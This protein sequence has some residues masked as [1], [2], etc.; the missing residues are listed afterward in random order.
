LAEGRISI[1]RLHRRSVYVLV[2]ALTVLAVA[3]VASARSRAVAGNPTFTPHPP[4]GIKGALLPSQVHLWKYNKAT[5]RYVT[6]PGK[7][8][9]LY[10]PHIRKASKTWTI[11][12]AEGWAANAFSVPIHK[13]VYLYAKLAGVKIIYCDNQFKTDQAISCAEQ[14]VS[15]HPDFAIESNWQ[16]GVVDALSKIWS[17]AHVPTVNDDVWHPNSIFF[18][19]NNYESG[20]IA[21][22]AAGTYAKQK[23]GC[24]DVWVFLGEHKEEGAAADL[25][26]SGFAD[27]VQEVCGKLPSGQINRE[28]MAAGTT[29]Q[30]ITVTTDWLTAHPQA[31]H[32]VATSIDD[33]R[34]TGMAKA[35]L[36]TRRDGVAAGQGADTVGIAAVKDAPVSKNDYLGTVAFFNNKYA[37]YM[38]SI[39][40]DVLEGKPVPQEVHL[41]HVFITH[42]DLGKTD[43]TSLP[44]QHGC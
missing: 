23:W 31:K 25:R 8:P 2:S 5:A 43:V 12:F 30:A 22:R 26:L 3:S 15:E 14:L 9:K 35:F 28:I 32:I 36:A 33:E 34:A 11:A 19:A 16:S 1:V 21:G 4:A 40:L 37:L 10:V 20:T 17:K 18:G 38:M 27:G 44:C 29:D 39:G 13:G 24:K 42:S 6:V 7:P 41:P